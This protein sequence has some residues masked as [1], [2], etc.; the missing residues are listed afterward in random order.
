MVISP[1]CL[2]TSESIINYVTLG[3]QRYKVL[4]SG[5]FFFVFLPLKPCRTEALPLLF[6][7]VLQIVIIHD[8]VK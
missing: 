3:L 4:L 2:V 8:K 7:K 5:K 1:P 6:I